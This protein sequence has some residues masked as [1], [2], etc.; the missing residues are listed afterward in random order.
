[1]SQAAR[2]IDR[3]S[4][5]MKTLDELAFQEKEEIKDLLSSQFGN[6]RKTLTEIEPE[7]RGT[8]KSATQKITQLATSTKDATR[9]KLKVVGERVDH[10][11]HEMPWTFI[12]V[13][14]LTGMIAGYYL[15]NRFS[16]D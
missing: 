16:K 7:V 9:E 13:S 15:G 4:E 14:A 11:V 1:M 6:L 12:G 5:A 10:K 8:L 2:N 3:L